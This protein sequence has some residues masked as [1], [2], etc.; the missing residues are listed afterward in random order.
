MSPRHLCDRLL[1][2]QDKIK[3]AQLR[4]DTMKLTNKNLQLDVAETKEANKVMFD[5]V[6][7][8]QY[9]SKKYIRSPSNKRF[10]EKQT[11]STVKMTN[12]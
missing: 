11:Q 6:Y 3:T 10:L 5:Q 12:K 7:G 1:D 2:L 9:R 8:H 4:N